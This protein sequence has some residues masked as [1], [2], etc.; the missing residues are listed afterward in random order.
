MKY[1]LA[2]NVI[3]HL[4]FI[5]IVQA[6]SSS[7]VQYSGEIVGANGRIGDF[8]LRQSQYT[9]ASITRENVKSDIG[10]LSCVGDP[11]CICTIGSSVDE[12]V[13]RMIPQNRIDDVCFIC[14]GLISQENV[15]FAVPH[16]GVLSIGADAIC[17]KGCPPTIIY[18]QHSYTIAALLNPL[19]VKIVDSRIE[20]DAY[21][22]RKLLWSSILWLLTSNPELDCATVKDAHDKQSKLIQN[23]VQ[24]LLPAARELVKVWSVAYVSSN[25]YISTSVVDNGIE[26]VFGSIDD[27][28]EYLEAYSYSMPGAAPSLGLA[29]KEVNDRNGRFL[30]F[31]DDQ[32]P[33]PLHEHLLARVGVDVPVL[34]RG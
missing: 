20:A 34:K 28:V 22:A 2:S 23:L 7:K 6:L 8:L 21:A 17:G 4:Y 13:Q 24:E 30:A 32:N 15:T 1:I 10:K 12:I 19:P 3:I 33:Q 11:I 27:V 5:Y 16:F 26:R 9:F 14:N 29:L 31:S 18:G 25:N